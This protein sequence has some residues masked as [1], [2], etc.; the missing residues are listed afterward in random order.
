MDVEGTTALMS[1]A[2]HGDLSTGRLLMKSG[3]D[4]TCKNA[5]N[6]TA[7]DYAEAAVNWN[8]NLEW[9]LRQAMDEAKAA[10]AAKAAAE[11]A[12]A[13]RQPE[14]AAFVPDMTTGQS[15]NIAR[16][17]RLKTGSMP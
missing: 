3:A 2:I 9:T 8:A 15:L 12:E 6:Y 5:F 4:V 14:P 13:S 17:L 11:A 16:P 10:A 1:A 7:F